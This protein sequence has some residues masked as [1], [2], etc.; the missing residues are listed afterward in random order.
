MAASSDA[1]ANDALTL[2]TTAGGSWWLGILE[3]R[4]QSAADLAA[5]VPGD[6]APIAA[7]EIHR[8]SST[9]TTPAARLSHLAADVHMPASSG[10]CSPAAWCLFADSAMTTPVTCG[11]LADS[12]T[13]PLPS[14]SALII[15]A[16]TVSLSFPD[17]LT[18]L[19]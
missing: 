4:P 8:N 9:W 7:I 13:G 14:G 12:L 3:S 11:W 6:V 16:A 17:R 19:P 2:V 18:V 5:A 10:I 15:P 1:F